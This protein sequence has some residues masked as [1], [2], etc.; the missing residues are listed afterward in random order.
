MN[1]RK[2]RWMSHCCMGEWLDGQM[3]N[4]FSA[5]RTGCIW[6]IRCRSCSLCVCGC[7]K[8]IYM[9]AGTHNFHVIQYTVVRCMFNV[10]SA[11]Q[12][13]LLYACIPFCVCIWLLRGYAPCRRPLGERGSWHIR[14]FRNL[15][16]NYM[17]TSQ[18]TRYGSRRQSYTRSIPPDPYFDPYPWSIPQIHTPFSLKKDWCWP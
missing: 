18:N 11:R 4:C 6:C 13:S 17:G 16:E 10:N 15:Q 5:F 8:G 12:C 2:I 14:H 9:M 1:G 3:G 7:G